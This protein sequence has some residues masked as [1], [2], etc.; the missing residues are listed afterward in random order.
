MHARALTLSGAVALAVLAGCTTTTSGE[1]AP[2]GGPPSDTSESSSAPTSESDEPDYSLA[3]LCELLTSDE[4]QQLGASPTGEEGNS[5][6]DGHDI[7]TWSDETY[8]IVG[9]QQGP[10]SADV[11]KGPGITNTPTTI[12][13]LTAVQSREADPPG[14]QVLVDLPSGVLLS[15]GA[16][17]L[18]A[19]EGK[20][21]PCE[22]ANDLANIVVPR[23]K[24]Q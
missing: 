23:V 3:R 15:V 18:S 11:T 2:S 21:E 4:A 12:D 7:C 13:G 20:Y 8:L 14:C 9:Y 16:G 1:P 17:P 19:G 24:D 6:S 10:T 22:L 5:T